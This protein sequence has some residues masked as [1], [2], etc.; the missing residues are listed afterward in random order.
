MV[1]ECWASLKPFASILPHTPHLCL[2]L[3]SHA[4]GEIY[5]GIKGSV[6]PLPIKWVNGGIKTN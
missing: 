2:G 5:T 3:R 4:T 6:Y 1:K